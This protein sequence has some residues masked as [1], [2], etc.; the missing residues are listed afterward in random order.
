[1][2]LTEKLREAVAMSV[3]VE[4]EEVG[5][6]ASFADLGVDSLSRLELIALVEQHVGVLVPEDQIPVLNSINE[7]TQFADSLAAA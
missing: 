7:V 1:M 2:E 5:L 4:P 6:D 3:M